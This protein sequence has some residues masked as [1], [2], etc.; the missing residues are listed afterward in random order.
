MTPAPFSPRA[1]DE[2]DEA[3]L[4]FLEVGKADAFADAVAAARARIADDPTALPLQPGNDRVRR[5][6]VS[7]FRYDLLF[8]TRPA[9]PLVVAVW[10]LHR[11]PADRP[12]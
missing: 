6:R 12:G 1:Q 8:V 3:Y 9:G 4:F 7:R 10:H 5:C 11:D 2:Y